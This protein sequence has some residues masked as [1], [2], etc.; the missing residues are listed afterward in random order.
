M[1]GLRAGKDLRVMLRPTACRAGIA[2]CPCRRILTFNSIFID[3][4]IKG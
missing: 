3:Q 1:I 2:V 4:S